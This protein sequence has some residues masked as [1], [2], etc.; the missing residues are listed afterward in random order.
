[1]LGFVVFATQFPSFLFSPWGGVVSDR[2]NRY[3]VLLITQVASMIQATLMVLLVMF[4]QYAA[5][6]IFALSI[7]L[8][9]INAFDVP[10][11]QSLIHE[12]V[13][14]KDYLPNAIALNSSMVNIARLIGPALS[15]IVLETLGAGTCFLINAL[16]FVAVIVSLLLMKLPAY[17]PHSSQKKVLHEFKEGWDYLRRTPSIG[18][19]I[20]LLACVSLLVLPFIALLPVYA[21]VIFHGSASTFGFINSFIGV[22]AIG[23]AIFLASLKG[24]VDLKKVLF[25]NLLIFGLGLILF[26]HTTYFPLALVFAVITG[27]GMMSQTTIINTIIQTSASPAMRGRVISYFAMAFFGMQPLGGLLIGILA[28]YI[29]TTNTILGQ[30]FA[31]IVI[32]LVFF[33]F[34]RKDLLKKEDEIKL[35]A[36]EDPA[37]DTSQQ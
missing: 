32:A 17:V 26:S 12:I 37:V 31:A 34:L 30:G 1:M 13:N 11:R 36:L 25:I 18:Y 20:L 9:T 15:G 21:K 16:S 29:G 6:E 27:F 4:T 23:G 8:G 28:T 5:W 35:V 22:G 2:N 19:V 14:N 3:R 33:P 10:A 24:G 7:V